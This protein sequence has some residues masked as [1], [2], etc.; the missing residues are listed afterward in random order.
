VTYCG[1]CLRNNN[2]GAADIIPVLT[3]HVPRKVELPQTQ[4]V[5]DPT[6]AGGLAADHALM[7][8]QPGSAS[9]GKKRPGGH[10]SWGPAPHGKPGP[11]RG[12]RLPPEGV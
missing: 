5:V 11:V 6:A 7:P 9:K 10:Q 4:T 2:A 8:S 12:G 3:L 1:C